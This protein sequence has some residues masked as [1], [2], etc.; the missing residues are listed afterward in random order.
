MMGSLYDTSAWKR[1]RLAHLSRYPWCAHCLELGYRQPAEH[2]DHIVTVRK[3]PELALDG[4][5]LQSLCHSC[6]S[7]K[8]QTEDKG[9]TRGTG[10]DGTPRDAAHHW[11]VEG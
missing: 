6:H 4:Q 5:N 8:T 3:A 11:N 7:V 2:V 1:L 10:I 9:A